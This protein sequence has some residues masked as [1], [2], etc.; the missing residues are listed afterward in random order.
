MARLKI[1]V[2]KQMC[3]KYCTTKQA[4]KTFKHVLN[5]KSKHKLKMDFSDV[6]GAFEEKH[7]GGIN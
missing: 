2:P 3:A 6:C 4:R 1:S 5:M 7:F